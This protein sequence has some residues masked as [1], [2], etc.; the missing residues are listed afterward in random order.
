MASHCCKHCNYE[1]D[2]VVDDQLGLIAAAAA[3][4]AEV[5]EE[6][7]E[8][9]VYLPSEGARNRFDLLPGLCMQSIQSGGL[10]APMCHHRLQ[11]NTCC[12][13]GGLEFY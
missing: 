9:I 8:S 12:N 13:N 6:E 2:E 7:V 10:M 1:R 4:V 3:G 11:K 5:A